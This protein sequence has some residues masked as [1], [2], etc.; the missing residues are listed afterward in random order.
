M[1]TLNDR[2]IIREEVNVKEGKNVFTFNHIVTETGVMVYRAEFAAS[3]NHYVENNALASINRVEE[4][5]RILIVETEKSLLESILTNSGFVTDVIQPDELPGSLQQFLRYDSLNF[6]NVPATKISLDQ[7]SLIKQA[8]HD[9]G[10]GFV[11]IGG[12]E[13]FGL[14]A[15]SVH[16]LKSSFRWKWK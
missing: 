8:V 13:S 7:M 12:E 16:R 4:K 6:N 10:Q 2:D 11:M 15:I 5:Q 3:R 9:F 1:I 14:G